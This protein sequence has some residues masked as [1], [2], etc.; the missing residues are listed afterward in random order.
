[1]KKFFLVTFGRF[2]EDNVLMIV[3]RI[4]FVLLTTDILL[5]MAVRNAQN[6]RFLITAATSSSSDRVRCLLVYLAFVYSCST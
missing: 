3:L 6:P 4:F 1:M 2:T 5:N